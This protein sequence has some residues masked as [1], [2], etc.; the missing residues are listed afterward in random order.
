MNAFLT[1]LAALSLGG[2]AVILLLALLS[3]AFRSRYG[4]RWRCW[5]WLVL[6]LRLVLPFSLP[7]QAPIQVP[8][9][10]DTV[11]FAPTEA[12]DGRTETPSPAVPDSPAAPAVPAVPA[13]QTVHK[14]RPVTLFQALLVLWL[15][16]ALCVAVWAG[17]S[18]Y[19]F[20]RYVRRWGHAVQ[21][22]K[23]LDRMQ[24]LREKLG[25]SKLPRLRS[26]AGVRAPML[27][28]IVHPVILLP[29]EPW[30]SDTLGYAL[31]H[32]LCHFKRRDIWLKSLALLALCIHWFNPAVWYMS[33]LIQ[34]DTELAC[35]EAALGCLPREE[36]AVYGKTILSAVERLKAET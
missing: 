31:L 20:L 33:H 15:A 12:E 21:E 2:A 36:H 6:C 10:Q 14:A 4:A 34:R 5:V 19:R 32:E 29:E 28:G 24:T 18:H 17:I 25:L 8:L 27:A 3:H 35:D 26:C 23:I 9:P 30:E 13:P 16:G 11:I 22:Q 1:T 7:R